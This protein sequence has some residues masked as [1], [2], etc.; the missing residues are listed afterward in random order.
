MSI[1][2]GLSGLDVNELDL[3]FL[4]PAKKVSTGEFRPVVRAE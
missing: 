2:G 3:A 1:L 4:A